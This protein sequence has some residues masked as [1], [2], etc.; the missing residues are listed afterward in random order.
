M[1]IVNH[2]EPKTKRQKILQL[3]SWLLKFGLSAG[4]VWYL[5]GKIGA[6]GLLGFSSAVVEDDE[7]GRR[8]LV[9]GRA[10]RLRETSFEART[11]PGPSP[12]P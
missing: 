11:A 12:K 1:S 6:S 8:E 2:I 3:L 9:K 10:E 7:E 5:M 4:L